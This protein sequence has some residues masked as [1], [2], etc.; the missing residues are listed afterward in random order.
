MNIYIYAA[1]FNFDPR[2]C[3]Q[4]KE[5]LVLW[6]KQKLSY[7]AELHLIHTIFKM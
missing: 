7:K 2:L 4:F 1:A 6:I 3:R 5:K